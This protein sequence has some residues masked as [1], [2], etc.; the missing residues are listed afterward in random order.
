MFTKE[1]TKPDGAKVTERYE[2]WYG[3]TLTQG[4][5]GVVYTIIG[6]LAIVSLPFVAV[7]NV[8]P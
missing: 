3:A 4:Y 1:Y 6:L 8:V 5:I 2:S 7:Y